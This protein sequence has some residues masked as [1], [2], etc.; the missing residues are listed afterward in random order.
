MVQPLT[1]G[2]GLVCAAGAPGSLAG[3]HWQRG[4]SRTRIDDDWVAVLTPSLAIAR[5][6]KVRIFER[7]EASDSLARK[8][9]SFVRVGVSVYNDAPVPDGDCEA[10]IVT[11]LFCS[12][13][14]W[15]VESAALKDTVSVGV[16]SSVSVLEAAGV[17]LYDATTRTARW[18]G[19][20]HSVVPI[21]IRRRAA[22]SPSR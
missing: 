4:C 6:V 18:V 1:A 14:V 2:G 19:A 10:A 22:S 15:P 13:S 20:S 21:S 9:A 16:R 17:L 5:N 3:A 11:P 7:R 12:V 8:I